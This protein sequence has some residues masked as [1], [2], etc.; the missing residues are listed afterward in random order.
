MMMKKKCVLK[1]N[2]EREREGE[3]IL[4]TLILI[5]RL[6]D[7]PGLV[8]FVLSGKRERERERERE[9]REREREE[10]GERDLPSFPP[11]HDSL[12]P[13]SRKRVQQHYTV[14]VIIEGE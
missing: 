12:S 10:R 8:S 2:F 13:V 3:S 11:N 4:S 6:S 9:K 5:L 7:F 1:V 14:C